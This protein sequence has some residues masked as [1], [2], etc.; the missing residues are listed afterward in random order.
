VRKPRPTSPAGN[1]GAAYGFTVSATGLGARS[2]SVGKDGSAFG[3]AN[4][5]T[6]DVYQLLQAVYQ[7]AVRGVLYN[8]DTTLRQKAADLFAALN[9][10]GGIG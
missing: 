2:D 4:S 1:A 6:L 3:V 8:G 10:A 7:R 5:T 9:D